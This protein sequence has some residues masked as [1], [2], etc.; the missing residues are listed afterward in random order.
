M[1]TTIYILRIQKAGSSLFDE[2][3][4]SFFSA[5]EHSRDLYRRMYKPNHTP[6]QETSVLR[7]A[8][9]EGR[10]PATI[11]KG[12]H[13]CAQTSAQREGVDNLLDPLPDSM[14]FAYS[15]ALPDTLT[16][17]NGDEFPGLLERARTY[18]Q[19]MRLVVGHIRFG[20][21]RLGHRGVFSYI[22]MLR[23]PVARVMSQWN[24]FMVSP[25]PMGSQD[26]RPQK[27]N[28]EGYSIEDWLED[29]S[30]HVYHKSNHMTRVLCGLGTSP[31]GE[32]FDEDSGPDNLENVTQE[33][34]ECAKANLDN[35]F[36]LVFL[37]ENLTDMPVPLRSLPRLLG[38]TASPHI[39]D[40]IRPKVAV[41]YKPLSSLRVESANATPASEPSNQHD[42][43]ARSHPPPASDRPVPRRPSV[44][45]QTVLPSH[46]Q[47]RPRVR[48]PG[49]PRRRLLAPRDNPTP[50]GSPGQVFELTEKQTVLIRQ[51]NE[52]DLLLYEHARAL[53]T[54]SIARVREL[55]HVRAKR[56]RWMPTADG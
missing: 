29:P 50:K 26:F 55:M 19:N 32:Y 22:T 1:N 25:W 15:Y 10:L 14:S 33:H 48:R 52:F 7:C 8:L 13:R 40:Q 36:S 20:Y 27:R 6:R 56:V 12:K 17:Y 41:E 3:F 43:E 30:L 23:H 5:E 45:V 18:M 47:A 2:A 4:R 11:A 46:N 38:L 42:D 53:H 51:Q 24:W 34:L 54:E 16:S 39:A 49:P 35:H 37:L 21:H 31:P 44:R 9:R 28:L